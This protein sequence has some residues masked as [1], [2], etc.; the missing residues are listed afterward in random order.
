MWVLVIRFYDVNDC[1][2]DFVLHFTD[3]DFYAGIC[4]YP[5][6]QSFGRILRA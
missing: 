5:G 2:I 6:E 1:Q 4:T 3:A